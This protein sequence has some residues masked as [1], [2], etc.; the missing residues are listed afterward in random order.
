MKSSKNKFRI[1]SVT[2][3][4]KRILLGYSQEKLGE[5]T[6]FSRSTI[7]NIERNTISGSVNELGQLARILQCEYE[8]LIEEDVSNEY[9]A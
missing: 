7:Q 9:G 4:E 6:G 8:E 3:V 1:K 5:L 2:V